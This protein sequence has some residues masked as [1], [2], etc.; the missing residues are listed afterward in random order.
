KGVEL[1]S[2]VYSDVPTA[3]RGDPGRLRQV[4]VNLLSNAVKFTDRGEVIV[5]VTR[6]STEAGRAFIRF[7]VSD[8]GIGIPGEAQRRIFEVCSQ[9]DGYTTRKY[10]GTGLG[11]AISR[12]LVELLGGQIN[13]KS[14]PGQ[15]STFWFTC[16]FDMQT[17]E[18]ARRETSGTQLE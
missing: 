5:R 14:S 17:Y 13:V 4:L 8:T 7:A 3:L 16:G 6:E 15:G 9:A 18:T 10:G 2:I 1:F 12:Q 11:L